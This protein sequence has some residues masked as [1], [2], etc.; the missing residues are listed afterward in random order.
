MWDTPDCATYDLT[1]AM[2]VRIE[3]LEKKKLLYIDDNGKWQSN[4]QSFPLNSLW[5]IFVVYSNHMRNKFLYIQLSVVY[6]FSFFHQYKTHQTYELDCNYQVINMLTYLKNKF[7][8]IQL[9]IFCFVF[10][11]SDKLYWNNNKKLI[12]LLKL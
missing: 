2:G 3:I 1:F 4:P 11:F 7:Y 12:S 9:I 6:I 10:F 5:L 8:K